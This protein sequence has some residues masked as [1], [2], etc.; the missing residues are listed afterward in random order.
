MPQKKTLEE[1][2]GVLV[3]EQQ[4]YKKVKTDEGNGTKEGNG[5]QEGNGTAEK[6]GK[7]EVEDKEEIIDGVS[8]AVGDAVEVKNG[9]STS[10]EKLGLLLIAGNFA[11]S[12]F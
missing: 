4:S 5:T 8:E 2:D 10:D 7:A 3:E 6:N 9:K 12:N 1:Q 11:Y